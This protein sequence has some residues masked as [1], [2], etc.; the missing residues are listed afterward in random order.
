MII[1][2][3]GT[4]KSISFVVLVHTSQCLVVRICL[5][6]VKGFGVYVY[7]KCIRLSTRGWYKH[8]NVWMESTCVYVCS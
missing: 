8:V 4:F 5:C 3:V 1:C 7:L 6:S 2:C